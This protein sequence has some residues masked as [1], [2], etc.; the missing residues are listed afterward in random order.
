[1][2]GITDFFG[3]DSWLAT[4]DLKLYDD[5]TWRNFHGRLIKESKED[6]S[7][8]LVRAK[9]LAQEYQRKILPLQYRIE[10]PQVISYL[11]SSYNFRSPLMTGRT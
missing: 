6:S 3:P 9:D 11:R 2:K 4:T 10:M 1:M 5:L 8:A 7:G